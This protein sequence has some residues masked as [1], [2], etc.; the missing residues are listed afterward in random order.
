M[1]DCGAVR[2]LLPELA[3]DVAPGDDRARALRHLGGCL[4]CRGELARLTEVV[5][6]LL[7]LAPEREPP[8]GFTGAVLARL[9]PGVPTRRRRL[10]PRLLQAAAVVAAAALAAGAVWWG[11]ADDRELA[12]SYR[13]TL[14]VAHGRELAAAPLRNANGDETGT[15]FAYDGDPSWVYVT[16]RAKPAPG[17]YGVRLLAKDGRA[18]PLRPFNATAASVAWGSTTKLPVEQIAAIEFAK[19][20]IPVMTARFAEGEAQ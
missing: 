8:A 7:L 3:A 20:D 1:P 4:E 12:E 16:F 17:E 10:V 15:V 19:R 18:L 13:D 9:T 2:E 6:S 14:A 5:D 11:T